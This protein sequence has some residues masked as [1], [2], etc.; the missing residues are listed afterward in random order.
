MV[1]GGGSGIRRV[2]L[3]RRVSLGS[4]V[5]PAHPRLPKFDHTI[6]TDDA[7]STYTDSAGGMEDF[8]RTV[9]CGLSSHQ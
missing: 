2:S 5:G 7:L 8:G 3:A 9:R 6:C 1:D 4:Q